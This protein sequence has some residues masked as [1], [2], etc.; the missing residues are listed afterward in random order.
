MLFVVCIVHRVFSGWHALVHLVQAFGFLKSADLVRRG[1]PTQCWNRNPN[2]NQDSGWVCLFCR[3]FSQNWIAYF[4][5]D[6]ST[7]VNAPCHYSSLYLRLVYASCS[8]N[9]T[10]DF[11][12]HL[13][14]VN[15]CS[16]NSQA[17]FTCLGLIHICSH[18]SQANFTGLGLINIYSHNSQANF[19][20]RGLIN[21][22]T[23]NSQANF[24]GQGLVNICSHNSQANRRSSEIQGTALSKC[25]QAWP[26]YTGPCLW[27]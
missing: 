1:K 3:S 13:W 16:C 26:V 8:H 11:T 18:D 24:T 22:C 25:L 17:N 15:I 14:L 10:A 2:K 4:T 23:H 9:S 7:F 21:I 5:P 20:G 6:V 12:P 19:T 27:V